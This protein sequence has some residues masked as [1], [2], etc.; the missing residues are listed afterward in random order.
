MIQILRDEALGLDVRAGVGELLAASARLN[1]LAA[2]RKAHRDV[3][4]LDELL[5]VYAAAHARCEAAWHAYTSGASDPADL[6]AAFRT[7]AEE[8]EAASSSASGSGG[9]RAPPIGRRSIPLAG[10]L[11]SIALDHTPGASS[12]RVRIVVENLATAETVEREL[13]LEPSDPDGCEVFEWPEQN[14]LVVGGARRIVGLDGRS[15]DLVFSLGLGRKE[16]ATVDGVRWYVREDGGCAVL[17]TETR[18]WCLGPG[19]RIAIS[20]TTQC[21]EPWTQILGVRL[22]GCEVE[23]DVRD[24]RADARVRIDPSTGHWTVVPIS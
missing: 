17:H 3:T 10:G 9:R 13:P 2:D 6:A 23:V 14:L 18:L 22:E 24:H 16:G 7:A 21:F 1:M 5:E 4:A 15:L 20:W 11:R 19:P 8:V 12:G